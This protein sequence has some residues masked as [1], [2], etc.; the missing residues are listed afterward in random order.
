MKNAKIFLVGDKENSLVS[1]TETAFDKEDILQVLLENYP[2]LLP[3]E[4]IDPDNPCRWLLVAR[5]LGVPSETDE[6]GRWSLDHLFLDQDG[7]PTFVECKRALDTRLRREVV[8]QM[9]DYAANGT[10]YWTMDK[11]RQA[12]TETVRQRGRSLDTE[13]LDL[14]GE[15]D[16][17][18]I[19]AYWKRVEANLRAG[20]VRLL[21]VSDSIPKE[22]RR[23][24]EFL[25]EQMERTEVLAVEIKQF[26]GDKHKAIVPRVIGA[27]ETARSAKDV[28][29]T[30]PKTNQEDFLSKCTLEARPFFEHVLAEARKRE[31]SLSWGKTGFS[32]GVTIPPDNR[33]SPIAIGYPPNRL[34]IW[35]S[36]YLERLQIPADV[37]KKVQKALLKL[38]VFQKTGKGVLVVKITSQNLIRIQEA[39]DFLLSQVDEIISS[40]IAEVV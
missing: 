19:E 40:H 4:Q 16:E 27:T 22:L 14:I 18:E 21:F 5:E 30:K 20:K 8:A 34:E 28:G 37:G 33:R 13:I 36:Y 1:M 17:S 3:G 25:N 29:E 15:S 9:L 35:V 23:L 2:D 11:L 31:Q 10:E 12:A 6:A 32:V 24:V 7:V 26:V 38:G 39:Y